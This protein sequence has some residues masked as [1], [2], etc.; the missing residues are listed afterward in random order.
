[1][2]TALE[3]WESRLRQVFDRIDD[4]LEDRYG[5]HYE[6]HPNR[7]PRGATSNKS[8]DGLFEL[9]AAYSAGFGS[10]LGEGYVLK[11]RLVTL[12]RVPVDIREEIEQLVVQ[13]LDERLPEAFPGKALDV[14]RDGRVYKI[15]GDLGLG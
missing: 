1:M 4:L 13:L 11:V 5:H 9:S 6:L 3:L 15:V 10:E 7:P 12:D 2:P 8:H 14:E